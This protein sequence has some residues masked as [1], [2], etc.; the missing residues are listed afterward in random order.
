M[1]DDSA[2]ELAALKGEVTALRMLLSALI[3]TEATNDQLDGLMPR[4][5]RQP[6]FATEDV[7]N[8]FVVALL[9]MADELAHNVRLHNVVERL[10]RMAD[11]SL[12]I[13]RPDDGDPLI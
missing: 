6:E 11:D 5:L 7:R 13:G 4:R 12:G 10:R 1:S 9:T 8:G 2:R 3:R